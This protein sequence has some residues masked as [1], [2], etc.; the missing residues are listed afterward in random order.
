M[1]YLKIAE[2]CDKKCTYCII[3]KIAGRFRSVPMDNC[4]RKRRGL[5]SDG[6]KELV[7]VAQEVTLYGKDRTGKKELPALLRKLCRLKE[8]NGSGFC[9]VTLR[10]LRMN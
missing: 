1:A 9:T 5:A 6:V 10:K 8:L 7:L 3:P 4:C 2:G